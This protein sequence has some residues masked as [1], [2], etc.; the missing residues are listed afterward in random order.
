M[1]SGNVQYPA[2]VQQ[3]IDKG[4]IAADATLTPAEI[5]VIESMDG[6]QLAMYEEMAN[7]VKEEAAQSGETVHPNI[8]V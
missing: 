2:K 3:L 6:P 4:V 1:A 8:I 7:K 5:T